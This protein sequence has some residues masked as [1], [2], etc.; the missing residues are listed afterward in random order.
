MEYNDNLMG[1]YLKSIEKYKVLSEE[2]E[3]VLCEKIIN[4]NDEKAK[5]HL[6][7]SNLRLVVKI[8]HDFKNLGVSLSDLVGAG[9]IGLIKSVD[10]YKNDKNTKFSTYA[11]LWIKAYMRK[12][13]SK[14]AR[15]ISLCENTVSAMKKAN[16]LSQENFSVEEIAEQMNTTR[17]KHIYT[18]L[19]GYSQFSINEKVE[20]KDGGTREKGD[21]MSDNYNQFEQIE[22]EDMIN[23]II[24]ICE[25]KCS[26][27]DQY[28]FYSRYGING[29]SLKTQVELANE[30]NLKHQRIQQIEVSVLKMIK[31]QLNLIDSL[32]S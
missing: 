15:T 22:K 12:E 29:F 26:S 31:K 28:I 13:L 19:N 1:F 18:L 30:L 7:N 21:L 17:K 24:K 3:K 20:D 8:A 23:Q 2:E 4:N 32:V 25:E 11:A 10:N 27:R 9:N 14:M 5:E 16:H 6:I